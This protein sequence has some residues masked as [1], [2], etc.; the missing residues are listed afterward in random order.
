[1]NKSVVIFILLMLMSFCELNAQTI[2]D[3]EKL[4]DA[5][6]VVIVYDY[7]NNIIGYGSGFIIDKEGTVVSC[8][9]VIKDAY[10]IK[11][12]TKIG[13]YEEDYDISLIISGDECKDIVKM[14]IDNKTNKEFPYLL[15]SYL[16]PTKGEDCWAIGTPANPIYMN[17]ASKGIIS[18]LI[19][20][21]NPKII[22]TNAE[23]SH[24]SSG[25]A[26][27]N[28]YGEVIGITSAGDATKDGDRANINFAIWAGE[29]KYLNS[30]NKSPPV[31]PN[32][33]P[34]QI[35]FYTHNPD[36]YYIYI[37]GVYV[38]KL[39]RY[40]SNNQTP[41]CGG[42]Y[43]KNFTLKP[44]AHNYKAENETDGYYFE[45]SFSL[46]PG[47]CVLHNLTR[48][49]KSNKETSQNNNVPMID[50]LKTPHK[51]YTPERVLRSYKFLVASGLSELTGLNRK[52][53]FYFDIYSEKYKHAFSTSFHYG[54][55]LQDFSIPYEDN[56][57]PYSIYMYSLGVEY[58]RVLY[59][60]RRIL[61][62]YLGTSLLTNYV[63]KDYSRPI[64]INNGVYSTNYIDEVEK[65]VCLIPQVFGGFE[66]NIF[67]RI[68]TKIHWG[69][70]Y[71][72]FF[73]GTVSSFNLNIGYR[74]AK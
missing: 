24:G 11:I 6:V 51:Y 26:L 73:G 50:R 1:M 53:D 2:P 41:K 12:R 31:N 62:F 21:I 32:V 8:Y 35:S 28:K 5:V 63:I 45:G 36:I 44:G 25:G 57:Y 16:T 54:D 42:E 18:N 58:R 43:S 10:K 27:L 37:D 9:H 56:N 30:I 4:D 49:T 19:F 39:D 61:G 47:D 52:Y 72:K 14:K 3:I 71:S 17:T 48:S 66:L 65:N 59:G 55:K 29:L 74:F 33:I 46:N 70:G 23:I 69:V 22:Q 64:F 68:T 40:I 34:C 20:N 13:N 67:Q 15:I 60:Y 38:G 7:Y